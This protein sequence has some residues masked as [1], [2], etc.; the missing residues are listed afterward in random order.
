[1]KTATQDLD[2]EIKELEA[3]RAALLDTEINTYRDGFRL[4]LQ[5]KRI[6]GQIRELRQDRRELQRS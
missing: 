3:K 2:R 1:M 5:L 6:N 4:E